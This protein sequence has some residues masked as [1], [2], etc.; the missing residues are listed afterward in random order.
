MARRTTRGSALR[1]AALVA[2]ELAYAETA[3]GEREVPRG[4]RI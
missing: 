4:W 2:A 1:L 3:D